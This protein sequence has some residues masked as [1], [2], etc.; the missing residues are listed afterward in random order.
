MLAQKHFQKLLNKKKFK[1]PLKLNS[2]DS[3]DNKNFQ[4]AAVNETVKSP[5]ISAENSQT[6]ICSSEVHSQGSV[7]SNRILNSSR[8]ED[9]RDLK[10]ASPGKLCSSLNDQNAQNCKRNLFNQ[11]ESKDTASKT[12]EKSE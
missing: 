5:A 11:T 3:V 9:Q 4:A 10:I 2:T 8:S 12:E 1:S 7:T 6:S